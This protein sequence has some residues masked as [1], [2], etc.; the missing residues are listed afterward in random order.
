[1]KRRIAAIV[2]PELACELAQRE[3]ACGPAPFAVIVGRDDAR[4]VRDGEIRDKTA[5][6]DA[7]DRRAWQ[8]GARPGQSVS[9]A[10]AYVGKLRVVQ[11]GESRLREALGAI[12]EMALAF[13]TNAALT[14]RLEGDRLPPRDEVMAASL[15]YP[16]GAAAGPSDTVWLDV[17]GCSR[18][19]GGEDILVDELESRVRELGHR[20]RVA[21]ADGPRIAQAI[22]RWAPP[23]PPSTFGDRV[24]PA[25]R[26]AEHLAELPIAALPLGPDMVAWLGKLGLLRIEDLARLDRARLSHRLGAAAR[27]LLELIAGRDDV[28]LCA[29]QPT[30]RIVESTSFESELDSTEPLMFALR[31]LAARAITR[32]SAR[33][34]AT[35]RASIELGFDRSVITLENHGRQELLPFHEVLTLELPVP[36]ARESELLRALSARLERTELAAP[37]VSLTLAL[38][39]L[40]ECEQ[41]QL[42]LGGKAGADPSAMPVLLAELDAH[43]GQGR[44]GVFELVDTHRPEARSRLVP[45][46][47]AHL[48]PRRRGQRPTRTRQLPSAT[49]T[50]V[51][52]EACHDH[53][54]RILPEPLPIPSPDKSALIVVDKQAFVVESIRHCARIEQIDWWSADPLHRDYARARLRTDRE[55]T[56]AWI[57][58]DRKTGRAYLQGWFD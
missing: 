6:L 29:H 5:T 56:E 51:A 39:E 1:M 16:L 3:L 11:L 20:A 24:I 48:R 12:A 21:I 43:L 53:P 49:P 31:G 47:V 44:V 18:L 27:D 45:V 17:T 36:L 15:R 13:G 23:A 7:V 9:Q 14:L 32:L 58:I 50:P 30:R 55:T 22:A 25:G 26:S 57:F 28:P 10:A 46:D 4:E 52:E 34:E 19:L 33:G 8:F 2:A 37:V 42:E 54:T 41:H 38:E 35:S 40:S